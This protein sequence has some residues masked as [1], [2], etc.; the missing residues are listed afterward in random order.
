MT[1]RHIVSAILA[2]AAL[3]TQSAAA[4]AMQAETA[5]FTYDALG[6][7]I[8]VESDRSTETVDFEFSYDAADNRTSA[9]V[10]ETTSSAAVPPEPLSTAQPGQ[11][12]QPD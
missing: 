6:R 5:T 2:S 4:N 9:G 10:T 3:A 11:A 1:N 12:A 8:E 7:V